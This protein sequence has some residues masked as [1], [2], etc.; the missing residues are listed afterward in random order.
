MN[1]ALSADVTFNGKFLNANP[2]AIL[3]DV[4][5]NKIVKIVAPDAIPNGYKHIHLKDK[6]LAPGFIDLQVNGCGGVNFNQDI[7]INALTT[8]KNT[9]EKHATTGFLPTL[10]TCDFNDVI[11]ALEVIKQW[12][13]QYGDSFGVLGI[14]LEGPFISKEKHGIH[15]IKHIIAPTLKNLELIAQYRKY[16][17]IKLT[18]APEVFTFDQIKYLVDAGITLSIGHSNA[19][20]KT[21]K[22][23]IDLGVITATHMFNAMSG[24]SARN[25][26]V[27]GSFLSTPNTFNGII[28]DL[29]HVDPVNVK[30][31]SQVKAD[32][33]YLVSDAVAPTSTT[34]DK[35]TFANTELYVKDG[36]CV[37][38]N[39][40]LGGAILTLDYAVYNCVTKCNIYPAHALKM[41]SIIP[42]DVM[43][44]NHLGR[45]A[46]NAYANFI[47]F[48]RAYNDDRE[49]TIPSTLFEVVKY[50]K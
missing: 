34:M 7:S 22:Q 32:T 38:K 29:L 5:R 17:P 1:I 13:N 14:H 35:F 31:L 20:Y 50:D 10:I 21:V 27:I 44:F 23:A 18:I 15:P 30:L 41:A 9:L 8:M 4:A 40:T 39:G 28:V 42:S 25:P 16:F 36:K 2:Y 48:D 3:I 49:L 37:D 26:G 33:T 19:D 24:L 6:V 43:N 12:F 47:M 11:T 46:P 45:I